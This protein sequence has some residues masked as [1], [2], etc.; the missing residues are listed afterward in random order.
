MVETELATVKRLLRNL[1]VPNHLYGYKYLC[2]VIPK[3]E[4]GVS[5][6]E[7]YGKIAI[8]QKVTWR[9]VERSI[10]RALDQSDAQGRKPLTVIAELREQ[11]ESEREE[12]PSGT[13]Q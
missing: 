8:A 4:V 12:H 2:V 13:D 5:L 10:A 1:R 7:L 9:N 3:F 6:H 11:F